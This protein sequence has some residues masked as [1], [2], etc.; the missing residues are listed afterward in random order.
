MSLPVGISASS[1]SGLKPGAVRLLVVG[2]A[3][4]VGV[5]PIGGEIRGRVRGVDRR[6][7]EGL[8]PPI[9]GGVLAV[10]RGNC[11][12]YPSV[13]VGTLV[14]RQ[15]GGRTVGVLLDLVVPFSR[16]GRRVVISTWAAST[17][18]RHV[19]HRGTPGC[20][21]V[22]AILVSRIRGCHVALAED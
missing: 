1:R 21:A 17:Y 8:R 13:H 5:A 2:A 9:S 19:G 6:T 7:R 10:V 16:R 3:C 22:M 12:A 4:F 15:V 14:A 20:L 18:L 11:G